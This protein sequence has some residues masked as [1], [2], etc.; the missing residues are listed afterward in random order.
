MIYKNSKL[1]GG[2]GWVAPVSV[3]SSKMLYYVGNF[4]TLQASESFEIYS[5]DIEEYPV[6][7][8]Y[9]DFKVEYIAC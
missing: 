4:T 9:S 1:F 3:A 8:Y 5:T 2:F 7:F 6:E